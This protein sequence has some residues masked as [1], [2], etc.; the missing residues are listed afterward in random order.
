MVST[1]LKIRIIAIKR[2][3]MREEIYANVEVMEDNDSDGEN[4]YKDVN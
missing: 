1:L 3:E 4:S 2:M